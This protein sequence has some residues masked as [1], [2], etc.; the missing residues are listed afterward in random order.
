VGPWAGLLLGA[1]VLVVLLQPRTRVVMRLFP[2]AALF[3]SGCAIAIGQIFREI[4]P[5][6]EWPTAYETF[7]TV[8]WLAVLF[9]AA[10]VLIELVTRRP[11]PPD[12][13]PQPET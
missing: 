12:P 9:L 13:E 3:A 5:T 2:A 6:F 1:A 11:P 4:P 8:A 10:D 7:H